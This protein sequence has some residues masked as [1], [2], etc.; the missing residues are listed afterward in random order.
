MLNNDENYKAEV[1]DNIYRVFH[2]DLP[3]PHFKF[4][5]FLNDTVQFKPSVIFDVGSAVLHWE[6][7]AKR[8]WADSQIICFDAFSPLE[9]LYQ[10]CN[11]EYNIACLSDK[12]GEEVKFYQNDML[13]GGNSMFREIGFDKGSVFPKENY[14]E[15]NSDFRHDCKK[16][17][18]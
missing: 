9:E 17:E 4:L 2:Q 5:E 16:Q 8:I 11:I 6:S 13:F 14:F 1:M 12:D 18:L 7:H 15:N 3:Y 10:K